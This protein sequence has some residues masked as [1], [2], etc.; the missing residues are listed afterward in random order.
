MPPG[1]GDIEP[2]RRVNTP[3]RGPAHGIADAKLDVGET[4]LGD[5]IRSAVRKGPEFDGNPVAHLGLHRRRLLG[6]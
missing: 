6:Q 4:A 5:R 1:L 3:D 2:D